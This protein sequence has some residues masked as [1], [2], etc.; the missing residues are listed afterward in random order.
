MDKYALQKVEIR[1]TIPLAEAEKHYKSITKKKPRKVRESANFY[2]FRYLPPTKFESRS[3]RTK[4][5]NDD[6]RMVFGKLKEGH[7]KLE[8][9]G[10]FDYFTKA[11]DYVKN[12]VSDAFDYVKDAIS[13]TDFS[14]KTKK[15]LNFFGDSPI[16]AIQLRRVPINFALDLALQGFSAGKW[17][18]LKEKY[19]FD[20]FFHLSMVVTLQQKTT[21]SVDGRPKR[22]PKQ[23]AIEKLEVISVNDNI[24]VGEGM[25]TQDV[26]LA[27]ASFNI[28]DMFQKTRAK[29]GDT[30]FFSYSALGGNNCQDFIKMILESEGL[31]REPEAQFVYQDLTQLVKELPQTTQNISQGITNIGALANKYLGIGGG[32]EGEMEGGTRRENVLKRY[33]LEDKGYSLKELASIT[34]VPE[35]TLQEVYNRG[36]GAY[37]T[38]PKSVRLKGSFV[39]NVDAPMKKKLSKEQW[40]MARVYSFLDGNPKHDDDLRSN[41]SSGSGSATAPTGGKVNLTALY[42]MYGSDVEGGNQ[43]SGFIRAM[44]A[45]DEASPEEKR[46]YVSSKTNQTNAEKFEGLDRRGFK[47]QEMTKTTHDLARKKKTLTR[48]EAIKRFYDYVIANAPQHQPLSSSNPK[49]N[50][51][52]AYDLDNMFD[53]WREEQG[54]EIREQRRQRREAPQEVV[55]PVMPPR[56]ISP[57]ERRANIHRFMA[58]I[59]AEERQ[60]QPAQAQPAQAQPAPRVLA[61]RPQVAVVPDP[62]H[63]DT[64]FTF[65]RDNGMAELKRRLRAKTAQEL[66]TFYRRQGG[67]TRE[68]LRDIATA[69]GATHRRPPNASGPGAITS[70]GVAQNIVEKVAN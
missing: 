47:L 40:A 42:K 26:P 31:Y 63:S 33:K 61:R 10:L 37:K 54:V 13:I 5:V 25:E 18:Q 65:L 15:N 44:M 41:G 68:N 23:L 59:G 7:Q 56:Y 19:G 58:S 14:E 50:Y 3:F 46:E 20:K 62:P 1:N 22:V 11:Y 6:I 45:R 35:K 49:R 48:N 2:Q 70:E 4:V 12:K 53:R 57:E 24:E 52:E 8:G 34:S 67:K 39:K 69:V 29:V 27:G 60:A 66:I 32:M 17:E 38:Q 30:R 9:A 55:S 51:R 64:V 36:I 28:K 43:K 21:I 16:T